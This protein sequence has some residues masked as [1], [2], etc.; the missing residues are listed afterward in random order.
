MPDVVD[1]RIGEKIARLEQRKTAV[2]AE[3][4]RINT[5]LAD[6]RA[7]RKALTDSVK[8]KIEELRRLEVL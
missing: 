6:I 2:E 3:L 8:S 1:S 5:E 7:V 4:I